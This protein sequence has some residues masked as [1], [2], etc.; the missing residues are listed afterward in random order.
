MGN[1]ID[2]Q[3]LVSLSADVFLSGLLGDQVPKLV[4][5]DGWAVLSVLVESENSDSFLTEISRMVF[6]HVDSLVMLTSSLSSTRVMFSVLANSTVS[7][8]YVSS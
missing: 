5:I 2:N 7:H 6:E 4:K 1:A 8:G 3:S